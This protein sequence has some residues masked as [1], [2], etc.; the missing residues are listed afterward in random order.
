MARGLGMRWARA[1]PAGP[2][3]PPAPARKLPATPRCNLERLRVAEVDTQV[4]AAGLRLTELLSRTVLTTRSA[5]LSACMPLG[6][7]PRLQGK[8]RA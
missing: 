5:T 4:A 2:A 8:G 3:K 6:W 1:A 7:T